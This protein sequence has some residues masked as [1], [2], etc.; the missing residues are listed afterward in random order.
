MS[1]VQFLQP[2]ITGNEYIFENQLCIKKSE[3]RGT[4]LRIL[5]DVI[6]TKLHKEVQ[7]ME[8]NEMCFNVFL[9]YAYSKSLNL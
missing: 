8:I 2:F 3:I 5:I 9:L 4:N 6:P 7:N 1:L